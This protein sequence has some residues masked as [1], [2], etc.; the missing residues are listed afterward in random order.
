MHAL[1]YYDVEQMYAFRYSESRGM[2][3]I[4]K[5]ERDERVRK[6]EAGVCVA[7]CFRSCN[8]GEQRGERKGRGRRTARIED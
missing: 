1:L 4:E 7:E 8:K 3:M 6:A 5:R 2:M